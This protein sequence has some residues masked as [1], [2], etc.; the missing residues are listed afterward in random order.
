MHG[1]KPS[2]EMHGSKP[3]HPRRP[4]ASP[5]SA[6]PQQIV[7]FSGIISVRFFPHGVGEGG[8][9]PLFDFNN[10]IDDTRSDTRILSK[11]QP[12]HCRSLMTASISRGPKPK[13]S[14]SESHSELLLQLR[15]DRSPRWLCQNREGVGGGT[16]RGIW[17]TVRAGSH[18]RHLGT[19][20]E[21]L[22]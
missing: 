19:L 10:P 7:F 8:V 20:A 1:S 17:Q 15:L 2:F 12:L 3:N 13:F 14:E 22:V 9:G 4:S 21:A 6:A 16:P 11:K 18:K 5:T